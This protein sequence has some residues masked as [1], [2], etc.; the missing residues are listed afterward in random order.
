MACL[1]VLACRFMGIRF[2][3][4]LKNFGTTSRKLFPLQ[5]RSMT[6]EMLLSTINPMLI[7]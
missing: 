5:V 1:S 6:L 3:A 7:H 2:Q 4:R